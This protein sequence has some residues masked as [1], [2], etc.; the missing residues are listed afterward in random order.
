MQPSAGLYIGTDVDSRWRDRYTRRGFLA[1]GN[2]RIWTDEQG[3]FFH[4]YLTREPLF[5]AWAAV[6]SIESTAFHSSRWAWGWPIL[7][8]RWTDEGLRLSSAF[9]VSG[10]RADQLEALDALRREHTARGSGVF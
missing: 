2:G 8:V 1:R 6:E 10:G 3:I 4:R 9:L 5:I 7:K